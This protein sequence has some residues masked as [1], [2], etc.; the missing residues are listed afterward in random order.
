MLNGSSKQSHVAQTIEPK[1]PHFKDVPR[2]EP[3]R[4]LWGPLAAIFLPIGMLLMGQVLAFFLAALVA[5]LFGYQMQDAYDWAESS[6]RGQFTYVLLA[7]TLALGGMWWYVRR[8]Q[9]TVSDIGIHAFRFKYIL[10]AVVGFGSYLFVY[11]IIF[12]LIEAYIPAIDTDQPQNIGFTNPVG[13]TELVLTFVSLA[14]LP[15]LAEEILFRGFMFTGLRRKFSFWPVALI[16]SGL[17]AILHLGF[18][19]SAPLL[20]VA[21][22]DTFLLAIMLSYLREKTGTIWSSVLIH[23]FKNSLAF[24]VL[25]LYK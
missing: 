4:K 10:Y 11:A 14:V 6:I 7:E 23:A 2:L 20:W 9:G 24:S 21:A 1:G 16:T 22:V 15:P 13:T 5:T 12:S 18:G 3:S 19:D 8:R 17:F 25:Y